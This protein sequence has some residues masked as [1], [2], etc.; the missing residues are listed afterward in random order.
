MPMEQLSLLFSGWRWQDMLDIVFNAY[1]LFRLYVLFR[2][3][4][5][6]R[7]IMAVVAM[8]IIGRSANAMGLVITN[9]VMQGVITLATF[10]IIIVFRNE[11]SGVVRTRS[12]GF[13]LW[14]IPRT[15]IN[16][17]VRIITDAVVKLA[18]SKIG[19]LI[20]MPLKT[21]VDSIIASGVDINASLS[22]EL[23]VN[24]F[25]PGAPLHD[26][27]AVIQGGKITRAGTIL[28]LSQNRHLASKYG[29]RHRAAL[30]LTEQSDA[31]V[32]VVSEE[33]GKVSLVKDNQIH[34]IMDSDKIEM[35]IKQYTGGP[36]PVK[37]MRRQT[38]E[39]LVAAMVCLLCTT[40]LWLS[41][42][43]G[44]ETLANYDVPIEFMNSDKKMNIIDTSASR[45]RL[46]ISGARPLIN[47]LTLDQ[48]SIKISLDGTA[49]GKNKL[50][51]TRQNVQ[52]PPGIRLKNIE[53]DQVEVTLDAMV[54]KRVPVQADFSGKLPDGLIM[55]SISVIPETVKI[56]GGGLTL[57]SITTVFTEKIP[58]ENLTR[59][60][61][62]N[63]ALVMNPA[64]L[65]PD[66]KHKKVQIRYTISERKRNEHTES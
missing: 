46:L 57:D 62:V 2:G 30:G 22:R 24:I 15:Q 58:L 34:E 1:I 47:A 26:G 56:T 49:V 66:E 65:R 61:F 29:T 25:W 59:S 19:A 11:I 8:W 54:E 4:N 60:G 52:L 9:W 44:M 23:L 32:I 41:F 14:E 18:G 50:A 63:A 51:I 7:V 43:R 6:L 55:T 3:T 35:L 5:I 33:R 16:T 36:E 42:S 64:T 12:F 13:F 39:L 17:P 21:G 53:P 31:L 48:M 40:G 38:R 20:V 37:K 27:A 10:I 28:P 45:S